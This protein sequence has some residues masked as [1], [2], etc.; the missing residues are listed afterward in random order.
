MRASD[1]P[2]RDRLL[3]KLVP[4]ENGCWHWVGFID[5]SGYG[6]LGYKGRRSE[7][8]QR[9]VYQEFVGPIPDGHDIDHVCHTN[10]DTCPGGLPCTHRRC[11]NPAHL[12]ALPRLAHSERTAAT[13]VRATTHCPHGHQYDE[14]NTWITGGRRF[15]KTCNRASKARLR[16]RR[17]AAA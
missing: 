8:L 10:D 14:D 4:H 6:R 3:A 9:A 15:C 13:R 2:A 11:G 16:A 7:T 17:K 1:V 5:K 12:E